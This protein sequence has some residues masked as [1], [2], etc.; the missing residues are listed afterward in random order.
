MMQWEGPVDLTGDTADDQDGIGDSASSV[1]PE[2]AG[3]SDDEEDWGTEAVLDCAW[4][5]D[6]RGDSQVETEEEEEEVELAEKYAE[7]SAEIQGAESEEQLRARGMPDYASWAMKK[8]QVGRSCTPNTVLT[9][10]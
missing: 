5:G 2:E 7:A 4:S 10:A 6:D 3:I 8:L 1:A 9:M